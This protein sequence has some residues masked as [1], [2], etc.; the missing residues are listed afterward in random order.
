M[1]GI[2]SV[3]TELKSLCS[4]FGSKLNKIDNC[5]SDL[6]NTIVAIEGQLSDM[7]RGVSVNTIGIG[8]TET[9][10]ATAEAEL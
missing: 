3:L 4:D 5:L 1:A 2:P 10:I 7:E 8:E 9:C 6:M